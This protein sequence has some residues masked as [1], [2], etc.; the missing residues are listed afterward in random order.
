L[1]SQPKNGR[2]GWMDLYRLALLGSLLIL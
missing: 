1:G 2:R